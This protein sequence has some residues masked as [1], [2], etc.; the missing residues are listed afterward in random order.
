MKVKIEIRKEKKN[1][2][3]IESFSGTYYKNSIKEAEKFIDAYYDNPNWAFGDAEVKLFVEEIE[4]I[5]K[6]KKGRCVKIL[7]KSGRIK[8]GRKHN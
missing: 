3:R 8:N 5:T 1:I 4:T 2:Y 7:R 6:I